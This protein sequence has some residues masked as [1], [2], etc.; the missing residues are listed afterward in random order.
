MST[1]TKNQEAQGIGLLQNWI[2]KLGGRD[3]LTPEE[4]QA[5]DEYYEVLTRELNLEDL[6]EFL[7]NE[8][9]NLHT[10]LREAVE[11]GKDRNALY[12]SARIE[13]YQAWVDYME[14]PARE[15][16]SLIEHITNLTD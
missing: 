12:I 16:E 11:K 2:K 6:A 15:K 5:Y 9:Y 14:A 1:K 3:Q 7:K 13:N 8:I 10:K 4:Q